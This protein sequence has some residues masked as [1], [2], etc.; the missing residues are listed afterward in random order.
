[1]GDLTASDTAILEALRA[2]AG[3][4]SEEGRARAAGIVG[5][6]PRSESHLAAGIAAAVGVALGWI[7]FHK[8]KG[9]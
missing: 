2:S 6:V 4:L 7:L 9:R 5:A 8:K 1:M 3:G